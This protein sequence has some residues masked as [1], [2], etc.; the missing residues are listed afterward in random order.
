MTT[1]E[2]YEIAQKGKGESITLGW[3]EGN[4]PC[5]EMWREELCYYEDH[6]ENF[7]NVFSYRKEE[8]KFNITRHEIDIHW[9][10]KVN[11]E[12]V[13]TKYMS[14][15]NEWTFPLLD[16]KE[17]LELERKNTWYYE[18]KFSSKFERY[19]MNVLKEMISV[20]K[21]ELVE[22]NLSSIRKPTLKK[23]FEDLEYLCF[24]RCSYYKK[25]TAWRDNEQVKNKIQF[26]NFLYNLFSSNECD[27][28]KIF[29]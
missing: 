28:I 15:K 6:T 18:H 9:I 26:Y 7:I 27:T 20:R 25:C 29:L 19:W 4:I 12:S 10:R 14:F 8:G 11:G 2:L 5:M 13:D 22:K 3:F 24:A 1:D 23:I 16:L 21:R 17:E